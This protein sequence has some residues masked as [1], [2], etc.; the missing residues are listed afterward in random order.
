MEATL[1]EGV[2]RAGVTPHGARRSAMDKGS[3]SP[4]TPETYRKRLQG[5]G[6]GE[7]EGEAEACERRKGGGRVP[8][9]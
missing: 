7:G 2:A 6:E 1:L 9:N 4:S 8:W 5:D 3:S